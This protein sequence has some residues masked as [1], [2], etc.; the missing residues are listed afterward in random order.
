MPPASHVRFEVLEHQ[1]A[2]D[3]GHAHVADEQERGV[4]EQGED[5][6]R[7]ADDGDR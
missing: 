2:D 3:D 4:A 5:P 6:D 7:D 1:P